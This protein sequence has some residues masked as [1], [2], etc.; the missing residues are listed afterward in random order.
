MVRT[1]ATGG[2]AWAA[3]LGVVGLLANGC[4]GVACVDACVEA[5]ERCGQVPHHLTPG[6]YAERDCELRCEQDASAWCDCF[7]CINEEE[8]CSIMC[9]RDDSC[10]APFAG[11]IIDG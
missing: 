9:R 11:S 5:L 4:S 7:D 2:L 10:R 1:T 6:V 3:I 8:S